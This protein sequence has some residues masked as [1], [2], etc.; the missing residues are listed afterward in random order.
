MS[1]SEIRDK[2]INT[3]RI[4]EELTDEQIMAHLKEAL[5]R[6]HPDKTTG[7]ESA[8]EYSERFDK[9]KKLYDDF[10]DELKKK[11]S[12]EIVKVDGN[13]SQIKILRYVDEIND[14]IKAKDDYDEKERLKLKLSVAEDKIRELEKANKQLIK[15]LCT[16]AKTESKELQTDLKDKFAVKPIG[17]GVSI[18]ILLGAL[19]TAISRVREG[20]SGLTGISEQVITIILVALSAIVILHWMFTNLQQMKVKNLINMMRDPRWMSDKVKITTNN[21]SSS[22]LRKSYVKQADIVV[23]ISQEVQEH[24]PQLWFPFQKS[25]VIE[26]IS[27]HVIAHYISL[28]VLTPNETAGYN[29]IFDIKEESKEQEADSPSSHLPF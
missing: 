21:S 4:S 22:Y 16:K 9:L 23:A 1:M 2:I 15:Q 27:G 29:V 12:K 13:D 17:K 6:W 7:E 18:L 28:H 10:R 19:T 20:L 3:L 5:I 24:H 14:I 26:L 25:S 8:K 11:N